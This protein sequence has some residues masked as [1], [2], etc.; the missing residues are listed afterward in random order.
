MYRAKGHGIPRSRKSM[1]KI[2][3]IKKQWDFEN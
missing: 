2:S 1:H 3:E